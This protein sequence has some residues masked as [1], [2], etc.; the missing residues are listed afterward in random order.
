MIQDSG[1]CVFLKKK[2]KNRKVG[3]SKK[4]DKKKKARV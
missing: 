2:K 1:S 3:V 4:L